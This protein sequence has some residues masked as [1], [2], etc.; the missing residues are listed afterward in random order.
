MAYGFQLD[1]WRPDN[2]DALFP[3]AVSATT[4][5]GGNNFTGS[6][7]WLVKSKYVR[8][9][10]VQFGYD[11]KESVLKKSPFQQLRLFVSGTNLLTSSNSTDYFIDP[12][13]NTNN[14]DYPIQRTFAIGLNVGF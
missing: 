14:Y 13:S 5:N 12:E 10:Y 7:F 2:T 9:K 1:Y 11:F 3:R 6:D 8:L 4:V